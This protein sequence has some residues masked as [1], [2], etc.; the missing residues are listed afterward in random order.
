MKKIFLVLFFFPFFLNA[1]LTVQQIMQDPKWIGTSPSDIVWSY[2]S[3]SI[4]FHWNPDKNPVDSTYAYLL[5][6]N[7]ISKASYSIEQ[8]AKD[9]S[10][11]KYNRSRTKIVF[12][13][14]GDIFLLNVSTGNTTRIT[15]TA[16]EEINPAF[17]KNDSDVVYALNN[18][19]FS[20]NIITGNTRQLSN[21]VKGN[22]P[23]ES[24]D[25]TPQQQ[26]LDEQALQTSAIIKRRKEK[27]DSAKAFLKANKEE[28]ELRKIYIATKEI[29]H[30]TSSPDGRFVTYR[31]Y[32][33]N[34]DVKETIVPS[35][36]TKDGY[37]KEIPARSKVGRPYGNFSFYIFDRMRDTVINVSTDSIAGIN[38]LPAY[39]K[40]YSQKNKDSIPE[41]RK[42]FIEGPY[43][44]EEGTISIVD[45]FSLDNK[46]RWIMQLDAVTGKLFLLDHQR[47]E[48]WIAGPGIAWSDAAIIGWINAGTVYFQ[49]ETTGY[50]H[51]YAYNINN[52]QRSAITQGKYE[53]QKAVI[54]SNK[55]YFYIVTNEEHPG[56]QSIYRI[57]SDGSNKI[58]LNSLTG[59]YEMF[60]SPDEKYIAYRYSYQ[61]KPWELFL[62]EN[63]LNAKSIQVTN[64][65]MSD[66]FTAY[67]WRDTK[68]FTFTARDGAQV[69]ARIYEPK[70]GTKNNAAVIFVHGAGYLQNI[71]Y[72]WSYYFREMMFNNLLADKGYIVMDIDYRGSAGYGRDWRTGIYR[73]MGGKD[74]DD[75]VDAAHYLV[76]KL[77]IDS[78]RIGIY[79]GSYGGFIT[80]MALFTQPDV[81]KAGAALR[82]VTDWAHYD[83]EYTSA[84]LNEPF[85]DSIAYARSSPINFAAGLKNHLLICH[86]MVDVNVHF[87]DAVRLSQRLIE[88]GKDNWEL[89]PYPVEDHSFVESSS[90]TDE[91]KRILK[92]FDENLLSR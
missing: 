4:Y 50:S 64:K 40:D 25:V 55:K 2:N 11:G 80:L 89:A 18:N 60:L 49:S 44:N 21:F 83:H 79:G 23:V 77:D 39:T 78:T 51:L 15:Q 35:Y 53:I 14:N 71:H 46:D 63:K 74:L 47:D 52:H 88:L 82:P 81:F 56:K 61:T 12:S 85:T 8:F 24:K 62:Q 72:R 36:V 9:V 67:P 13:H 43:W 45:I 19:L 73:Y 91:Y 66:A 6:E 20:W 48:A 90:W 69:Y 84:I 16:D 1:Q 76:Q 30:V 26:W 34:D 58:K 54:S 41:A 5:S 68:I 75:E 87:Q 59:G 10:H 29:Q 3:K 37:T 32:Q 86:G 31:L 22:E 27:A 57:N 65:A 17:I 70:Q 7:K 33:K 28:K 92:L 42:V 38:A